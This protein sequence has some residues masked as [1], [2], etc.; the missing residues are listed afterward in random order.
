MSFTTKFFLSVLIFVYF[1]S[2]RTPRVELHYKVFPAKVGDYLSKFMHD[3]DCKYG[4]RVTNKRGD[5]W[6]A[7]GDKYFLT[8]GNE[9][10]RQLVQEAIQKSAGQVYAA[11][12][13]PSKAINS[14]EVIDILPFVDAK[15]VN[16]AP[17]FQ[18]KNE[19]LLRRLDIGN[20]QDQKTKSNWWGIP[21]ATLNLVEGETRA[22][23]V[24]PPSSQA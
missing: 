16:N 9:N 15:A 14:N 23:S 20:L 18:M 21:T 1:L 3:E 2:Y 17:L 10:N 22:N 13:N 24:L 5:K 8:K 6:I 11:F 19:E 4:L 12:K 7:Y